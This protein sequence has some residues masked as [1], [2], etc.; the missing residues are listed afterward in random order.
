M[1]EIYRL[2]EDTC[3]VTITDFADVARV[4]VKDEFSGAGADLCP[5]EAIKAG[6]A[7]VE[8]GEK[9]AQ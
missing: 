9:N 7:L 3:H 1:N 4:E 8:W 5:S 6:R 2:R